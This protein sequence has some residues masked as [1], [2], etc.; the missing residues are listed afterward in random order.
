M[1]TI[2]PRK[3]DNGDL[4]GWQAKIRRR[5]F[6]AQSRTFD[7]RKA[8][9]DWAKVI[10]AEMIVAFTLTERRLSAPPSARSLRITSSA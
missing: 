8:A 7:S 9:E 4:I 6:P 2:V 5:G 1:A 3:N 10:E